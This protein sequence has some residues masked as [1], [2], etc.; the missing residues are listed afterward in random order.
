MNFTKLYWVDGPWPGKVALA[1]RPRGGEWLEDELK[2]WRDAGIHTVFSLLTPQE[3]LCLDLTNEGSEAKKRDIRF[4][5]FPIEDRQVPSSPSELAK[6]LEHIEAELKSGRNVVIHCRQGVGRTG[7]VASCLLINKGLDAQS[8]IGRV[9]SARGVP[10]PETDE[11]R[12]WIDYYTAAL[13][14]A[15]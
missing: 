6:A 1:A 8:A 15:Q 11:Q 9:K 3:E 7:L 2:G 14:G 5:S 13:A 12:R 4:V 10:I